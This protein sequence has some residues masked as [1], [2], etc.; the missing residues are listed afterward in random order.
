MDTIV[1][2]TV[3]TF[4][5]LEKEIYRMICQAGVDFTRVILEQKDQELF[6]NADKSKYHS[7]GFRTTSIKTVYGPVSYKR[8]VYKTT[9]DEL[10]QRLGADAP[11]PP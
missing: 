11:Q 5:Q 2:D 4:N 10:I 3:H 6:D 1:K 8:R 7:E 9:T